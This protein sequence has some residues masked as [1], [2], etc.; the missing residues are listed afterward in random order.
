MTDSSKVVKTRPALPLDG[1]RGRLLESYS[2]EPTR[3][4]TVLK[5]LAFSTGKECV[6]AT[7]DPPILG[8]NLGTAEDVAEV[9][10]SARHEGEALS[11]IEVF[12]CFVFVARANGPGVAENRTVDSSE[13]TIIGWGELSRTRHDADRHAFQ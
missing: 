6:Q 13:L 4:C 12:P 9:Y 7:L 3:K 8:Q 2:L 5:R 1:N 10:L 11:P